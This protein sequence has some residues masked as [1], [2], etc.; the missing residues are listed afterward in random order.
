M[1]EVAKTDQATKVAEKRQVLPLGPERASESAHVS[2][3]VSTWRLGE[4]DGAGRPRAWKMLIFCRNLA[5]SETRDDG[6]IGLRMPTRG[7]GRTLRWAERGGAHLLAAGACR[8]RSTGSDGACW[9][10][11][12]KV[13]SGLGERNRKSSCHIIIIIFFIRGH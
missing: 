11:T 8:C 2:R 10:S 13:K 1:A 3:Y 9:N 12:V 5:L 4:A 7:R 6:I